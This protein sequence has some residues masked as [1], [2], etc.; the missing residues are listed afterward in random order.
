MSRVGDELK[1]DRDARVSPR[2]A[3]TAAGRPCPATIS[4]I[5]PLRSTATVVDT[6]FG[7]EGAAIAGTFEYVRK[8]HVVEGALGAA[9][10]TEQRS[11][12][13]TLR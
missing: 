1:R 13:S 7:P 4:S 11:L 3:L 8:G 9:C 12:V 10:R 5:S 6:F 2:N